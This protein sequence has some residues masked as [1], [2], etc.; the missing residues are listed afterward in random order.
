MISRERVDACTSLAS[1]VI[2]V[3]VIISGLTFLS[4]ENLGH[5]N[6]MPR[7]PLDHS[8]A[9]HHLLFRA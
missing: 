8:S 9:I 2:V 1:S 3:A 7:T 6:L 4:I 5:R